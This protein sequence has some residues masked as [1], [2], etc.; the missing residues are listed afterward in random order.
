MQYDEFH[1]IKI[2]HEASFSVKIE[3]SMMKGFLSITGDTNP[4]HTDQQFA[5]NLKFDDRVVYGM[6]T[7]S[8]YSTLV[9]VYLPGKHALFQGIDVQFNRPVYCGDKLK[10]RGEVSYINEVY[11]QIELSAYVENQKGQKVSKAKIKVGFQ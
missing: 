6:L 5:K 3:E 4:L 1:Q 11:R 8:F 9:G 2:G 7:A 10:I